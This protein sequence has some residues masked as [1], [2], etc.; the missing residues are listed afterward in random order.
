MALLEGLSSQTLQAGP[1]AQK[2]LYSFQNWGVSLLGSI[3]GGVCCVFCVLYV[4]QAYSICTKK[5]LLGEACCYGGKNI[6]KLIFPWGLFLFYVLVVVVVVSFPTFH[7]VAFCRIKWIKIKEP[8]VVAFFPPSFPSVLSL[9][10]SFYSSVPWAPVE[11]DGGGDSPRPWAAG[12]VPPAPRICAFLFLSPPLPTLCQGPVLSQLPTP[13]NMWSS[14]SSGDLLGAP[15]ASKDQLNAL[16]SC[17]GQADW[18][19]EGVLQTIKARNYLA[20]G[21]SRFLWEVTGDHVWS[22]QQWRCSLVL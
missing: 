1:Y 17:H 15:K 12:R 22:A 5:S 8:V 9:P 14:K 11:E 13:A 21:L 2:S 18:R 19:Q 16:N 7:W 3:S 20:C 6:L 4:T 10:F